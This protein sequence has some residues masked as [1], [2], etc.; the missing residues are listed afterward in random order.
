MQD[1]YSEQLSSLIDGELS[2]DDMEEIVSA[3]QS[4]DDLQRKLDRYG[5]IRSAI[6]DDQVLQPDHHLSDR[7]RQALLDEPT[8]L[9][10]R[11]I[12]W[13]FLRGKSIAMA[14]S[15]MALAVLVAYQFPDTHQPVQQTIVASQA[16]TSTDNSSQLAPANTVQNSTQLA[17][18]S[19]PSQP[20]QTTPDFDAYLLNHNQSASLMQ[21]PD[22]LPSARLATYGSE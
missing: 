2:E 4:N 3:M 7:V 8:V 16:S 19:T 21:M 14:A 6:R 12:N 18:V 13:G 11:T 9:A 17:V 22:M 1:Q 20:S 10:P 5:M 15:V